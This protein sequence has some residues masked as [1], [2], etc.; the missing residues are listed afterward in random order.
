M[1]NRTLFGLQDARNGTPASR[2]WRARAAIFGL[3]SAATGAFLLCPC[4]CV[5]V[6]DHYAMLLVGLA[7]CFALAAS[8]LVYRELG[9]ATEITG[10]LRAAIAA[11]L[12]FSCV[13][14]ELLLAMEGI[15]WLAQH[16]SSR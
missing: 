8:V 9:Q 11:G 12:V 16:G 7:A 2:R 4:D 6:H 5:N 3:I 13:F 1:Q 10:F 15:A 14:A